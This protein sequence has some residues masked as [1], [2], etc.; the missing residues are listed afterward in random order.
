M[1]GAHKQN[2]SIPFIPVPWEVSV[3]PDESNLFPPTECSELLSLVM[4]SGY[5]RPWFNYHKLY[6]FEEHL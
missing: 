4:Q 2:L 3:L 6:K 5:V 1:S